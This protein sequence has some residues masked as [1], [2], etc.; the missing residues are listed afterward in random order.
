[1]LTLEPGAKVMAP[2]GEIGTIT[3]ISYCERQQ[4]LVEFEDGELIPYDYAE[5]SNPEDEI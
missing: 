1:M 4:A 3:D 5:L 2:C